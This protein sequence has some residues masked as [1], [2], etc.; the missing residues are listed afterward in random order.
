M[1]LDDCFMYDYGLVDATEEDSAKK[2]AGDKMRTAAL[3]LVV[4]E[5]ELEEA[6]ANLEEA[7][8]SLVGTTGEMREELQEEHKTATS[9]VIEAEKALKKL[10]EEFK[11]TL[12][13]W[14]KVR[15]LGQGALEEAYEV[16]GHMNR[17][18]YHSCSFVGNDVDRALDNH[19]EIL[20][21][22]FSKYVMMLW[23]K[24]GNGVALWFAFEMYKKHLNLLKALKRVRSAVRRAKVL[25]PAERAE[26]RA[27][28]VAF[29]VLFCKSYPKRDVTPKLWALFFEV[30][31]FADE[32]HCAGLMAEDPVESIH[33]LLNRLSRTFAGM[34]NKTHREECLLR[35]V[36]VIGH[37]RAAAANALV[38][39]RRRR[40]PR[41]SRG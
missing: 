27:S 40:R 19:E 2:D 5:K 31:R 21:H 10:K 25:D 33:A 17:L 18:K 36:D 9:I 34:G 14:K 37:R 30:P 22:V 1:L 11:S 41:S 16:K 28:C 7:N 26:V 24:E 6:K 20:R 13:A 4:A 3:E 35:R 8:E 29:G 15:G 39:A 12:E 38:D 32:H 23:H